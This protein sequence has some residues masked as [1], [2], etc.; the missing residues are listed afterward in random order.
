LV[1]I[2]CDLCFPL[3]AHMLLLFCDEHKGYILF[4]ILFNS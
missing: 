4:Y 3:Y 1:I 2:L